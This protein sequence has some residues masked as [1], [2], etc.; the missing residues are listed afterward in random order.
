[1]VSCLSDEERGEFRSDMARTVRDCVEVTGELFNRSG[2]SSLYQG[3]ELN[4]VFQDIQ[5]FRQHAANQWEQGA[6]V[7]G[8]TLFGEPLM[9]PMA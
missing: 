9:D 3:S 8:A 6:Q 5:A 7:H 4:A 1:M 2:G